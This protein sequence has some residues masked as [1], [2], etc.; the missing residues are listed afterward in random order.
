MAAINNRLPDVLGDQEP[1]ISF[2]DELVEWVNENKIDPEDLDE[3]VRDLKSKEASRI[4]NGGTEEQISYILDCYAN[5]V[6]AVKSEI[7]SS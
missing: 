4:N 1:E 6:T 5:N 7:M 2:V 3:I